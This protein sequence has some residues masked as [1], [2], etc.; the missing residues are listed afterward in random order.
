[1]NT[2]HDLPGPTPE[3]SPVHISVQ[4]LGSLRVDRGDAVLDAHHLGGPKPRQILEILLV[5]LGTPVS[6]SR[7]IEL[8]WAG[9]PPCEPLPTLE[10]HVS[11]LRRH[12]QPG[13]G[14]EGPL[15]TANGGYVMNRDRV[16]LDL[17]LFDELVR[18]ARTVAPGDAFPLLEQALE[19]ARAPLLGD[20][21]VATW[22]LEERAIHV[23]RVN[24]TAVIAAE[25]A[26]ALMR[27]DD[28]VRWAK[29]ATGAAPLNE[30]AW[31]AL[32]LALEQAGRHA[33]GLVAYNDCR[34]LMDAELGC[35]PG[36]ALRAAQQRLLGATVDIDDGLSQILSALREVQR[37]LRESA[38][39]SQ[40][41]PGSVPSPL[42]QA[43]AVIESFLRRAVGAA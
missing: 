14:K 10:S 24:D 30:A 4:I 41:G 25:V 11:V 27:P 36:Y 40:N 1:M 3:K 5:H 17:D 12:L 21:L 29:W 33:E 19:L 32:V 20:E 15:Q 7:L 31:T 42:A 9:H 28:A 22:A 8:L 37:E 13:A 38:A 35:A 23:A 34:H 39:S 43:S 16:D 6:K 2:S 18:R 26:L